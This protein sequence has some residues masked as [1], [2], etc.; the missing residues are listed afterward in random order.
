MP[1]D[2]DQALTRVEFAQ[3]EPLTTRLHGLIR[4]YPRGVGL[5]Q[6]FVQNADDASATAVN[7]WLDERTYP[8]SSLPAPRMSSLQGPAIVVTND[9]CFTDQ[10]W[11]RLQTIGQ[12]GKS[13]DTSKTGRFGLGFNSVYNITDFP[14]ILSG[15]TIGIFDPHGTTVADATPQKPGG[16]WRLDAALWERAGDMLVPFHTYGLAT[17]TNNFDGTAFRLPLRTDDQAQDS[18]ICSS[19]FT[20]DDFDTIIDKLADRVGELLLFLNHVTK[21]EFG[22][23]NQAGRSR[24]VLSA[25]TLNEE[26][27]T[28][29][30][31]NIQGVLEQPHADVLASLR[32][33]GE[34]RHATFNHELQ[35]NIGKSQSRETWVVT[36]GLFVDPDARLLDCAEQMFAIEEKAVPLA[37]AASL[38][39]S[40]SA[41]KVTGRVYCGLPL[42]PNSPVAECHI[43][44]FFDL[45]PDRQGLFQDPGAE[46]V[47]AIRVRWNQALLEHGCARVMA[48]HCTHLAHLAVRKRGSPYAAWPRVPVET[49]DMLDELPSWTY[50]Q[51]STLDCI[52]VGKAQTWRAPSDTIVVPVGAA[53]SLYPPLL[54][55]DLPVPHPRLP[56]QVIQG[57]QACEQPLPRLTAQRL[58]DELRVEEDCD[59]EFSNP[60]RECIGTREWALAL[61]KHCVSDRKCDDLNGVPL[62]LLASGR[63]RSFSSTRKQKIFLANAPE[64][65]IFLSQPHWFIDAEAQRECGLEASAG[66]GLLDF[67]PQLVVVNLKSVLPSV[68]E[69]ALV[70]PGTCENAPSSEWLTIVYRYFVENKDNV[71][72][73]SDVIASLP[74]VPDQFGMLRGMGLASTPL[75]ASTDDQSR[76]GTAL[77]YFNVPVVFGDNDLMSAIR[78]FVDAYPNEAIWRVHP[79]DLIDTLEAIAGPQSSDDEQVCFRKDRHGVVLDY[80]ASRGIGELKGK[81]SDCIGTLCGLRLFP[82]AKGDAVRLDAADY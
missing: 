79:R 55:D 67:T 70:D 77:K 13:L 60:P 25:E 10:D 47:G 42:P 66:A 4:S 57:F 73:K 44:G 76:L 40:S 69:D 26:E 30:R 48:L 75:L 24:V 21:I 72:L 39:K 6:E 22:T 43:D 41:R 64:R 8:S 29:A 1:G 53:D 3:S 31:L 38:V 81:A 61:L 71:Q 56:P 50:S 68:N 37:G 15:D 11:K 46:G 17:G 16:A 19:P 54:A 12:S 65:E 52:A 34:S 9:A 62:G 2:Q 28:T 14:C 18:A 32:A 74:L 35:V 45:Q 80:L 58:R 5:I 63:I 59:F 78:A 49:R 23:V 7:I 36:R 33:D 51:L 20:H 27:V 82:S